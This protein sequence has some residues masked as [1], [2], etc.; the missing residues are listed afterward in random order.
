MR[1]LRPSWSLRRERGRLW[2]EAAGG[3]QH[4]TVNTAFGSALVAT[5]TDSFGNGVA[6][7]VVTFTAPGSSGAS[8][9][10]CQVGCNATTDASGQATLSARTA[11]TTAGG[12]YTVAAQ[13]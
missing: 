5:A 12:P 1:T 3:G 13:A 6:G 4:T 2:P 7:V 8:T 9:T 10:T 11:N